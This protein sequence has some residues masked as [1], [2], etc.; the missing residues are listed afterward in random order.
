MESDLGTDRALFLAGARSLGGFI[1][2]AERVRLPDDCAVGYI[3]EGLLGARLR[4]SRLFHSHLEN[5]RLLH[6]D[7]VLHQVRPCL[8]G[9]AP[10]FQVPSL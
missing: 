1:S 6:P 3:V 4:P 7:S 2:T 9:A 5:L 10:E 8:V